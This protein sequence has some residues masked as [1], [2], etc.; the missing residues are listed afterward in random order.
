[1]K[2]KAERIFLDHASTTPLDKRVYSAMRP[3]LLGKFTNPSALYGEAVEVK[4]LLNKFRSDVANI[5]HAHSNEVIFTGSGTEA[6]NLAIIGLFESVSNLH[7][8]FFIRHPHFVTTVFEHP[9]ILETFKYLEKRGAQV[10]YLPVFKDGFISVANL[11]NAL[12]PNTA[13]VS[14]MYA[15]NEIG[16][17]QPIKEIAK[18]IRIYNKN[19][20]KNSTKTYFHTDASQATN[21]CNINVLELG[22]D[23][24]TLD[25]SKI[26]GPKGVGALFV[27]RGVSLAPIIHGGGQEQGLR[28][29]TE[30][31]SGIAGFAKALSLVET[32]KVTESKRLIKL[33]DL[34][35]GSILKSFPESSLNGSLENRLPNNINICFPRILGELAVLRLDASG[36]S[37]SSSSSCRSLKDNTSSYVIEHLGK[38]KN[39]AESSLRISLGR[40]TTRNQ[41]NT[42]LSKLEL[43]YV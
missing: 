3:F 36:I 15:N 19:R 1:M 30:N 25:G 17:I 12:K 23:L 31:L 9:A 7:S 40:S 11:K 33:R 5:L 28:S 43:V 13:L 27:R 2:R 26:Y 16:T 18:T 42:L 6:D 22:V 20:A 38:G 34:A 35:I 39:C 37:I 21:Y 14:I 4:N 10:S 24:M 41:I 8:P 29:G 32:E